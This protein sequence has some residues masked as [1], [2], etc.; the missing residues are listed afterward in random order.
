[1]QRTGWSG[2]ALVLIVLAMVA[3]MAMVGLIVDGGNAFVQQR[4]AQNASDSAA[5]AGAVVIAKHALATNAGDTANLKDDAAVL[6]AMNEIAAI[7]RILPFTP[8]VAGNSIGH[9]TDIDGNLILSGGAPIQVGAAPGGT[10]PSCSG[11]CLNGLAAGV[12]AAGTRTFGTY[13]SGI[14]GLPGFRATAQATAVAGYGGPEC[15]AA[16]G[17]ALLPVTFATNQN[18]CDTNGD[19]IYNSTL[20]QEVAPPYTAANEQILSLCKGGEGAFGW[21]DYGC[22]N[23]ASQILTP[24]NTV[25]FPSWQLS[26]PGNPNSVENELNTYSGSIVGV[27]EPGENGD[28]EVLIPI[29]DGVCNEDRP[30]EEPPNPPNDEPP[31]F[32]AGAFPGE[33]AGNPSGGGANRHYHIKFFIGFIL[34]KAYVQGNNFPECSQLPGA[35]FPGGNGSGGCLKGWIARI[36]A[37]PGA[38]TGNPGPGGTSTPL[39]VQLKG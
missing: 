35:P 3:M 32:T 27:Y 24:C 1:M 34:D 12:R 23:V 7:N 14:I 9:Y 22:G 10:I 11:N 37:A 29:F 26:Q 19:A 18:T 28:E 39:M 5:E 4:D 15:D 6:T 20:W 2:Q 17:C 38:V 21:L 25:Y 33:C 31:V 30:G 36:V 8:G 13:V 16:Q